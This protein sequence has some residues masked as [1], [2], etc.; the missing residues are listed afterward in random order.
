MRHTLPLL[1]L[2]T[3][4]CAKKPAPA[5][6]VPA[7]EPAAAPVE[8]PPSPT[9][10]EPSTPEGFSWND[11]GQTVS[12]SLAFRVGEGDRQAAQYETTSFVPGEPPNRFT[13]TGFTET[14]L[15]EQREDGSYLSH[16]VTSL[17]AEPE[18]GF[19]PQI[20]ARLASVEMWFTVSPDA[21]QLTLDV[22][23][24]QASQ[25]HTLAALRAQWAQTPEALAFIDARAASTPPSHMAQ[26]MMNEWASEVLPYVGP[27]V[28]VGQPQVTLRE[29]KDPFLGLPVRLIETR[30]LLH[31]GPCEDT[32]DA[33]E[34]ITLFI[35]HRIHP[36]DVHTVE[37]ALTARFGGPQATN[38]QSTRQDITV[39]QCEGMRQESQVT[40]LRNTVDVA[41]PDGR[42]AP[43]GSH[44]VATFHRAP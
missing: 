8:T 6:P 32:P 27:N 42:S 13:L 22:E 36:D 29:G 31:A 28:P 30:G 24:A 12:C 18:A 11:N 2:V 9:P 1:A 17:E 26:D 19:R 33:S 10:L 23:K 25:E 20:L 14:R 34:C 15:E 44:T 38:L 7:E 43:A 21:Q 5:P 39:L 3:L 35:G 41:L 16:T 4:G 37:T 40:E